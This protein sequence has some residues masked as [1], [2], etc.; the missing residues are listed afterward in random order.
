MTA[1]ARFA[2]AAE[3]RARMERPPRA[4]FWVAIMGVETACIVRQSRVGV[5]RPR[6]WHSVTFVPSEVISSACVIIS[7]KY[8]NDTF[9][10]RRAARVDFRTRPRPSV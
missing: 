1:T 5:G 7:E 6:T 3:R 10:A 9:G 4:T 2:G 8:P